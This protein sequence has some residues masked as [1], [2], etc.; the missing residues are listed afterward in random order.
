MLTL[1]TVPK[2]FQGHIGII[3]RN[4]IASWVQLGSQVEILL[5]G[6]DEGTA[7][8][9]AKMGLRHFP[10][11]V[12]NSY[13]TP[14]ISEVFRQ[15]Q[16]RASFEFLCYVN[17]DI[18]LVRD[19][20]EAIQ[21][22]RSHQGHFLLM[23]RRW[24]LEIAQ[25]LDFTGDWER[26]LRSEL[27]RNGHLH[28]SSAMDYFVFRRGMVAEMPSFAIG[29]PA[30]DN[31]LIFFVRSCGYPVIDATS[32]ITV[33]HQG[34]EYSHVPF[35]TG[36]RWEGP[37]AEQNRELAG[38]FEHI[39]TMEDATQIL[40]TDGL[41][42]PYCTKGRMIRHFYTRAV[43]SRKQNVWTRALK[44]LFASRSLNDYRAEPK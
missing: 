2:G 34:H 38:G 21:R 5:F 39:F 29:R 35:G 41:R 14:L 24:D 27:L 25:L 8:T 23:G 18:I 17:A 40:T 13:G 10:R 16:E 15:A 26:K 33:V 6:D 9:A 37:E 44:M 22:M 1:F 32:V 20:L 3:Q 11:I 28:S 43:L 7:E 12:R 36:I 4:A 19:F 30:W 42:K 31:W